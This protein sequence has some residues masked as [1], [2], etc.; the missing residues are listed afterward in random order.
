MFINQLSSTYHH[1]K[2]YKQIID[3][4]IKYGFGYIV[5]KVGIILPV[6]TARPSPK[7]ED[8]LTTAQKVVM[9]LQELG[10]TFIKLGQ[11]LSTRPDIIPSNY[12]KELKRLQDDVAPFGFETVMRKIEEELGC[13]LSDVFKSFDETPL[14]SASIGQV[15]RAVLTN[16][17]EVVV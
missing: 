3:I 12:I 9:M 15:H 11:V 6:G 5:E 1:A 10:P 7:S 2:R 8:K 4:L 13:N 17:Q 16:G 14:A